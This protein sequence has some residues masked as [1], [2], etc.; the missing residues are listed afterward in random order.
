MCAGKHS[1]SCGAV[2]T[3][4]ST[5]STSSPAGNDIAPLGDMVNFFEREHGRDASYY[6]GYSG[7]C[8]MWDSD[9]AQELTVVA[10]STD[11]MYQGLACGTCVR[12]TSMTQRGGGDVLPTPFTAIIGDLCENCQQGDLD[13]AIAD[14]DGRHDLIWEPVPCPV[15]N[16]PIQ[17]RLTAS[18][19]WYVKVQVR[20]ARYPVQSVAVVGKDGSWVDFRN[21]GA[22]GG[23]GFF[24]STI[25]NGVDTYIQ[26]PFQYPLTVRI[27]D[28]YGNCIVDR[29]E[30]LK[31]EVDQIG[32]HQF[33][34]QA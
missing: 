12:V 14:K 6:T 15:N 4:T 16:E 23:L 32:L 8:L 31:N 18:H 34:V 1:D 2:S 33:P 21:A 11:D 3:T 27:C 9:L 10:V 26:R 13:F 17:F 20:H 22:L 29:I 28:I 24:D 30:E 25:P 19:E 7:G 5:S